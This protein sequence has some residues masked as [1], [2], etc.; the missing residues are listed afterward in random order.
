MKE[1]STEQLQRVIRQLKR[2]ALILT[3]ENA[4]LKQR[5]RILEDKNDELYNEVRACENQIS[6]MKSINDLVNRNRI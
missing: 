2:D 1:K 6:E 5:N 4:Q 3:K